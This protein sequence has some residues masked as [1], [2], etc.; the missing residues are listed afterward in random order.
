MSLTCTQLP[1]KK[2]K[3]GLLGFAKKFNAPHTHLSILL[4]D[5]LC[6]DR[7]AGNVSP[8]SLIV[9]IRPVLRVL[10]LA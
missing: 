8:V 4:P 1:A 6:K 9:E 10:V 7:S 2:K 5:T 3:K